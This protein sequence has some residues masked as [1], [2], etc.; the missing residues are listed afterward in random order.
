LGHLD[1]SIDEEEAEEIEHPVEPRD[2]AHADEDEDRAHHDRA[3]D[4]PEEHAVLE[5]RLDL[6]VGEHEDEDEDVV[7]AQAQL[8]EVAGEELLAEFGAAPP[9]HESAERDG[10]RAPDGAPAERLLHRDD[11]GVALKHPQVEGEHRGDEE[12]KR[13]PGPPGNRVDDG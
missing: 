2:D 8:D 6:E 11:V 12:K 7:H 9:P 1:A 5:A 10:E 3:D 4:A 13:A